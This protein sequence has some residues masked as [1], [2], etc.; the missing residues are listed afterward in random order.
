MTLDPHWRSRGVSAAEVVARIASQ[1]RVFVHG[2]AA[3]PVPLL[4]ALAAR[5]DLE[6]VRLYHLHTSGTDRFVDPSVAGRL[7]SVSF[8]VGADARPA[9]AAGRADFVPVFLSDIPGLF[10]SGQVPLDAALVQLS[11]PDAH[12]NCSLGTSVDA[13]RGAVD[14]APLLLAEINARMPRTLGNTVVPLSRVAAFTLTDRPLFSPPPARVGPVERQIGERV[15]ALVEDG[16]TL[17]MGIGGIPDAVLSFL[18]NR[19][20]LGCTPRCSPTGWCR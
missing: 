6:G 13:A 20:D 10:A 1:T 9:V 17:Q 2:A 3:T 18:G 11:P 4:D 14:H 7:R 15:A 5:R 16:A 12:G 8:F 19:H